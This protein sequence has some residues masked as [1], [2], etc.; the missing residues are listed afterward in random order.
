MKPKSTLWSR[1]RH[2]EGKH[3]VLREYLKAWFPILGRTQGRIVFIDGFA[4]P[5]EY[6]GGEPGSP[7]IAMDALMNHSAAHK[8]TAK[9]FFAFIEN[10]PDRAKYLQSLVDEREPRFPENMRVRVINNDFD[11]A[12]RN[13][14]D[15]LEQDRKCLGPAFVMIDSFGVKGFSMDVIGRILSNRKCEVYITIMWSSIK[16]F[17]SGPEFK[18]YMDDIFGPE[19]KSVG[20]TAHLDRQELYQQYEQRLKE[21]GARYVLSFDLYQDKRIEYSIF[22][23]TWNLAGCDKM[24]KAIWKVCPC[25]DFS[26]RGHATEQLSLNG[27]NRP[28]YSPLRSALM[29]QFQG[30]EWIRIKDVLDFVKSDET[31]YHSDQVKKPVLRPMEEEGLLQVKPDSREKQWTYPDLCWVRFGEFGQPRLL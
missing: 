7:T 19:W 3:L 21:T 9:V 29:D 16:R 11:P 30:G 22:F 4:G 2:T 25:G 6:E 12:M 26:F 8:I 24:K 18:P 1:D 17:G 13:I 20:D 14:L 31:R 15:D 10:R 5:G 27:I 23:A 28:D